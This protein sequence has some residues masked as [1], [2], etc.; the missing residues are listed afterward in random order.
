MKEIRK[1]I[2]KTVEN[3]NQDEKAVEKLLKSGLSE[4]PDSKED[5]EKRKKIRRI[6]EGV[7]TFAIAAVVFLALS[8]SF[9]KSRIMSASMEPTLMTGDIVIYQAISTKA[10]RGDIIEFERGDE[11]LSKRVIGIAG[12]EISFSDDGKVIRNGE[13]I[14][15]TY[16]PEGTVTIP[17]LKNSY[18]VP[19]GS[20]FVLGDNRTNSFDSRFWENPYVE[21]SDIV[22][23]YLITAKKK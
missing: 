18:K 10:D 8:V 3:I 5:L 2:E 22:G 7:E 19:E 23:K 9:D 12:D 11:T 1:T 4:T 6:I 13:K 17:G 15:E 14:E 20:V 21:T 16:L